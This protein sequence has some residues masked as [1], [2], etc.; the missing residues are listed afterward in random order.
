MKIARGT[1]ASTSASLLLLSAFAGCCEGSRE[2]ISR[3]INE[4]QMMVVPKGVGLYEDPEKDSIRFNQIFWFCRPTYEP[5]ENGDGQ[6]DNVVGHAVS[7]FPSMDQFTTVG[8]SIVGQWNPH[9]YSAAWSA[10]T[11][12][13]EEFIVDYDDRTVMKLTEY[14]YLGYEFSLPGGT[15]GFVTSG[16]AVWAF[17][18]TGDPT[19]GAMQEALGKNL[20]GENCE[21]K[22]EE[23]WKAS[24]ESGGGGGTKAMASF[25]WIMGLAIFS[26]LPFSFAIV[27]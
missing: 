11:N 24:M 15:G 26:S 27:V 19:L 13:Y 8:A 1:T 5:D 14:S 3:Y 12:A 4:G 17:D 9:G 7:F 22:Y 20:T 10:E 18:A 6:W 2:R 16:D 23:V 21:A 25:A